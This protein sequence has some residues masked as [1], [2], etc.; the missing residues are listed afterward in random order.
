MVA[1]DSV[2]F[3]EGLVRVLT[4]LGFS[5]A[6][7]VSNADELLQAVRD[8]HPDVAVVDIR[9]PPTHTDEG[10]RA[11]LEIEAHDSDVGILLLSHLLDAEYALR[12]LDARSAGRG[13]LLKDRVADLD[14]FGAAVTSVGN[15]GSVVD[16]EVVRALVEARSRP[17]PLN[18]LTAREIEILALMA[19][20]RSNDGIR[21][22]LTLSS[23]TVE[24]HVRVIMQKLGLAQ[25]ADD[26]RRVLAVLTYLQ[27]NSPMF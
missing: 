8:E 9:M 3:R 24:S 19:Q 6:A 1:D 12:L 26:H 23:R 18:A 7:Q 25:A 17:A 21:E 13:Y 22:R 2:L 11:A 4:D 20:G 27:A 15:D 5:V 16:H 14:T 10:L